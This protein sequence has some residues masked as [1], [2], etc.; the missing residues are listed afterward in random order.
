[1]DN[2]Y[3]PGNKIKQAILFVKVLDEPDFPVTKAL[4]S[5]ASDSLIQKTCWIPVYVYI[6][7]IPAYVDLCRSEL[8]VLNKRPHLCQQREISDKTGICSF[9]FV[10]RKG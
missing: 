9:G 5:N 10:K 8:N 3:L 4:H 2:Q 7:D 1:M 6:S